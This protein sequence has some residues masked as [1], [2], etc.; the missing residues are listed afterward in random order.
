MKLSVVLGSHN[1]AAYIGEQLESILSQTRMPD[2]I[3][4]SDDASRDDTVAIARDVLSTHPEVQFTVIE[5]VPALGV[6]RNFEQA[7]LAA[8]GDLI[9]LADQDDI[10]HTAKLERIIAV[11]ERRADV[12]LVHTDARLVDGDGVPLGMSLL[13]SL[14][15]RPGELREIHGGRAFD[16]LLRRNLVTGATTVFRASLLR[17][18]VP[19]ADDWVHD[20][21]LAIIA[22]AIGSTEVLEDELIDY[23][24]HGG[25]QI[26]AEKLTLRRK[27]GKLREPR[28]ERNAHLLER[29]ESLVERLEAVGVADAR[30]EAARAKL[31]FERYRS[32]LP[33]SHFARVLPIV[34]RALAGDYARFSLGLPD[35]GRD[36]TQPAD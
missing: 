9:A 11:F 20:E 12:L 19:F 26:G 33:A 6:V 22:A 23:R 31:Q 36:L 18:A 16:T 7:A 32:A 21:W 35:M 15:A 24:Q 14:E 5:N 17:D 28:T 3:V 34:R 10:W 8:T 25:N 29:A 2:E 13:A 27:L 30:L 4:L 1:G